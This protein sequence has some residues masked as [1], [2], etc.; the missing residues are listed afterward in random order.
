MS[1]LAITFDPA[2]AGREAWQAQLEVLRAVVT[3]LTSKEVLDKID[4]AKSTLSEALHE[5]NDK[6]WAAEWTH[7]IKAMLARRYDEVSVDL[8]R[9]LC[10][11]DL[12]TTTL[13]VGEPRELTPEE[14]NQILR[15]ELARLGEQG[16]AALDRVRS[17][18]K[19]K[20]R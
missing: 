5:R 15:S 19:A 17:K 6:R 20:R 3:H 1:Q 8:L 7:V 13:V 16:V 9:K 4:V 2:W 10:D 11:F 12:A 14:E 18:G